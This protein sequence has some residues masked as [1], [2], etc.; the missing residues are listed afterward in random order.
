MKDLQSAVQDLSTL[1]DGFD[2]KN[3]KTASSQARKRDDP[4]EEQLPLLTG[5]NFE[6]LCGEKN[7]VCIVGAFRN[8]KAREKLESI[9]SE[10]S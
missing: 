6:A 9:L 2:K 1:L 3:K 10:A 4:V 7:P 8:S 5:L